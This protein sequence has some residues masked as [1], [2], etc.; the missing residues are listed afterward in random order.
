M[1]SPYENSGDIPVLTEQLRRTYSEKILDEICWEYIYHQHSLYEVTFATFPYLVDFCE[2]TKDAGFKLKT[3]LN[4]GVILSELDT[5]DI[6]LTQT[7]ANSKIEKEITK[8]IIASFKISFQKLKQIGISLFETIVKKDEIEKRYFLS[9]I[10]VANENFKVAKVFS[11][12]I[13]NDEYLCSCPECNTE[14]YLWNKDDKLVLYTD[15]PVFDKKQEGFPVVPKSSIDVQPSEIISSDNNF[16]WLTFYIDKLK[17]D[18]LKSIVNYLFGEIKCPEC[19]K[20]FNVFNA[21]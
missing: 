1:E 4:L 14:F 7:F 18:S 13:E 8:S 5:D 17:I 16:E 2:M 15:D 19:T 20:K 11:T 9:A 21:I 6:L 3:F 12:F 10:P